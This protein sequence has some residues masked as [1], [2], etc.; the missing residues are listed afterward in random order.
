MMTS[1]FARLAA[2]I[3]AQPRSRVLFV[4]ALLLVG[5]GALDMVTGQIVFLTFYAVPVALTTW[6]MGRKAGLPF[7]VAAIA[8]WTV[9]EHYSQHQTWAG[10]VIWWNCGM[11]LTFFVLVVVILAALHDTLEVE[12]RLARSDPLTGLAN[13]RQFTEQ[14][15]FELH[16]ARRTGTPFTLASFDVD[17]LKVINDGYGHAAGDALLVS[18][19]AAWRRVLRSTDLV[20]RLGGDEFAVLLP[21]TAGEAADHALQKG[22]QEALAGIKEGGW[23]ASLSIGAV[24]C[25]GDHVDV[26]NLLRQ[27]DALMYEVKAAGK[28][29]VSRVTVG[30]ESGGSVHRSPPSPKGASPL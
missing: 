1:F 21:D 10:G 11:R 2:F 23:P 25:F 22:R 29:G 17:D 16:R 4:S 27:A 19:A 7:A 6:V 18:V 20:A 24:S 15:Q 28:N 8:V 14:A 12:Q 30:T 26:D 9:T 3:E 5:V 13:L